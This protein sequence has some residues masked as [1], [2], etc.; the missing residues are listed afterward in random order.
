[1]RGG[2]GGG[3]VEGGGGVLVEVL[4]IPSRDSCSWL[5]RHASFEGVCGGD[6]GGP[7]WT[8]KNGRI[9]E[10]TLN[11]IRERDIVWSMS[12]VWVGRFMGESVVVVLDRTV[13]NVKVKGRAWRGVRVAWG[14]H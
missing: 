5:S 6:G 11:L 4:P 1:M 10:G 9:R 8:K 3:G 14:S 7:L 13:R 12:Y 2:G